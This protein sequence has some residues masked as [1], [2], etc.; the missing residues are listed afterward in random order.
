MENQTRQYSNEELRA[1]LNPEGSQLWK[2]QQRMVELLLAFDAIC[3]RHHI[4]YWLIGGTLIGAARHQGFIPWDDDMD[5]QMLREDYL[6]MIE[7][8]PRELDETMALQCRQ[9]DENYFFQ[10]AKLR[11]RRSVLDENN[12]YDRI[13]KERGIYIDI[14]PT[15]KHPKWPQR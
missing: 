10:Y 9:T 6:K 2:H 12:G 15:D 14:F 11:D 7:I 13:F 1:R 8:L 3:K 4:R 5:V